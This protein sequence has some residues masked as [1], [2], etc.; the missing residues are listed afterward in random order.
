MGIKVVVSKS[1][2]LLDQPLS[3]QYYLA[4]VSFARP[5]LIFLLKIHPEH[6]MKYLSNQIRQQALKLK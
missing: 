4:D 6:N 5:N 1:T 2:A 3:K